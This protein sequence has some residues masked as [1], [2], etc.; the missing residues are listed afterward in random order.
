MNGEELTHHKVN[1][2]QAH[3]CT[4]ILLHER[5]SSG[6]DLCRALCAELTSNNTT[7]ASVLPGARFVFPDGPLAAAEGGRDWY[8]LEDPGEECAEQASWDQWRHVAYAAEQIDM[9]VADEADIIGREN[10][11]IGGVGKGCAVAM[12]ALLEMEMAIGGF[13]GFGG[14]MPFVRDVK[15]VATLGAIDSPLH[16]SALQDAQSLR[17]SPLRNEVLAEDAMD[18]QPGN[19]DIAVDPSLL[20]SQQ[21]PPP[22]A[23]LDDQSQQA[24]LQRVTNFLRQFEWVNHEEWAESTSV[25]TPVF[26]VHAHHDTTVEFSHSKEAQQTLKEL[27]FDAKLNVL[28]AGGHDVSHEALQEFLTMIVSGQT[29]PWMDIMGSVLSF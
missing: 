9:I 16:P 15:D 20:T 27:G 14:W 6:A 21:P 3:N 28:Q 17:P 11:F 22:P 13:L 7:I 8:G 26:L 18:W 24:R 25:K 2:S 1:A 4:F 19:D 5:G 29:G 10:V 23:L 12:F